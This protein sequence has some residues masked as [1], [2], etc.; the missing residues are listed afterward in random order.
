MSR[1]KIQ[2]TV[3]QIRSYEILQQMEQALQR[4]YSVQDLEENMFIQDEVDKIK[5]SMEY[6]KLVLGIDKIYL[7]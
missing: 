1:Q 3:S 4:L 5:N 2:L 6:I 7:R